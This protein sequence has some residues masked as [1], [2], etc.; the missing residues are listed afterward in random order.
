MCYLILNYNT[1][2]SNFGGDCIASAFE[3]AAAGR[4]LTFSNVLRHGSGTSQAGSDGGL[5]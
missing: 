2:K 4:F 1:N 3:V 5:G